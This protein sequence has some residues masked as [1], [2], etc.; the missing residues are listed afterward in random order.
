MEVIYWIFQDF[1]R[2]Q[3][4]LHCAV[5]ILTVT[6]LEDLTQQFPPHCV[7]D[8]CRVEFF[9]LDLGCS[10]QEGVGPN[11]LQVS[12]NLNYSVI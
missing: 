9:L 1:Y 5:L 11:N 10:E 6:A 3:V 12:S 2:F 4:K 8:I 7:L